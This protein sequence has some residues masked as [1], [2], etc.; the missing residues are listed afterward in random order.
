MDLKTLVME[1]GTNEIRIGFVDDQQPQIVIPALIES[2]KSIDFCR[3][4]AT[5]D[6]WNFQLKY[7]VIAR[8]IVHWDSLAEILT[9][10][11]EDELNLKV[12]NCRILLIWP[13]FIQVD[14]FDILAKLFFEKM[15]VAGLIV[16]YGEI[17]AL[18]Y[19]NHPTGVVIDIGEGYTS[20]VPI[21][22]R[23]AIEHAYRRSDISGRKITSS[24]QRLLN[25]KYRDIPLSLKIVQ[26][27]KE[28]YCYIAEDYLKE[29]MLVEKLE[30]K[31]VRNHRLDTDRTI[32]LLTER[33]MT[34]ECIFTPS[35]IGLSELGL[36]ATLVLSINACPTEI[37]S[38]ISSNIFLIGGTSQ[39]PGLSQR[40]HTELIGN[41][42]TVPKKG[43]ETKQY[44]I[45]TDI[46]LNITIPPKPSLST[47]LGGAKLGRLVT[48]TK[49]HKIWITKEDYRHEG[50]KVFEK[51]L[52]NV[53]QLIAEE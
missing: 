5:I 48:S 21:V 30:T 52:S 39:V 17:L 37:Q 18:Y 42:I 46:E 19:L 6:K 8:N 23:H 16:I 14:Y 3:N 35:L 7:P 51:N 15:K 36:H 22:N 12:E 28:K 38:T 41:P 29:T 20:V 33:F 31:F 49:T 34:L 43:G 4:E 27:I 11:F 1:F 24:M 10:V 53:F 9:R 44:Q 50:I 32:S 2:T 47:W 40:L 45:P 26:E 25:Q 13:F